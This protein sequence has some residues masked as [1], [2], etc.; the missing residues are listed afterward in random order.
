MFTADP[1]ITELNILERGVFK[2]LFSMDIHQVATPDT[3]VEDARCFIL[4]FREGSRFTAHAVLST[5]RTNRQFYYS[6]TANPF[7]EE[8]LSGIEDDA[9]QFAED[10]GFALDE[11]AVAGMSLEQRN[12]WLEEQGLLGRKKAA[13]AEAPQA[14]QP[15]KAADAPP[16]R[17][18]A[19]MTREA[20]AA[21]AAPR[22]E[23][24]LQKGVRAGV[25]K[26]PTQSLR[27]DL[28]SPTSV[29][30]KDR[31]ALARLLASF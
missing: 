23:D 25:V 28:L 22:P 20:P 17:P 7:G 19:A 12:A 31:E 1:G 27:R 26:P 18:R 16:P 24:L 15:Q 5:T 13:P 6:H 10:M 30:P 2:V 14:V 8:Q 3:S 4:L 29:V 9:R 21:E 11:M